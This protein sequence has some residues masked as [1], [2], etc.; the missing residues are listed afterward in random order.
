MTRLARTTDGRPMIGDEDGFVPLSSADPSLETVRDALP[1]AAV[2]D[3]PTLDEANASSIPEEHLSFAAPLERPGKLWGIGLN[4]A[5]HAS[6]LNEN[7]P[8]EPASFMKPATAATGPNGS[9]R[10]PPRDITNRVTAEAELAIVIGRTCSNVDQA[11]VDD[12]IAGYVPVIDMTA[13]DILERNPR[14]LTRSKSF[15]S[16]LVFGSSIVTTDQVGPLDELSV[17][18][19]VNENIAAENRIH[20]MMTSPRELVSFHS[21]V[22]TLEPGDIISTGT[23]G[24][25]HIVPGDRVRAEV[26]NVGTV[27]SNV[28]G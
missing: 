5:D 15:D 10:L 16:F 22:M 25:K 9:I 1:L 18:T 8:T 12:V 11:V 3:L 27:S 24:A 20:N 4:Y 19:V 6:D 26:E 21:E 2:G 28:V 23:P 14:F 7:S 13:E 17:K